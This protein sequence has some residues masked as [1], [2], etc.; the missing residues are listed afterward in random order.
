ML[1][2][3][4]AETR[5]CKKTVRNIVTQLLFADY[6]KLDAGGGAEDSGGGAYKSVWIRRS[7]DGR[8]GRM[9]VSINSGGLEEVSVL[10]YL[11]SHVTVDDGID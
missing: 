1:K 10:K 8:V 6:S 3:L 5:R 4:V 11:E 7:R 2:P 9:S